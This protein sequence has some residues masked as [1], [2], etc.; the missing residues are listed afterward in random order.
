M[1]P[2]ISKRDGLS[3]DHLRK[4]REQDRLRKKRESLKKLVRG[5]LWEQ[6]PIV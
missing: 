1:K 3:P 2:L 4:I 5:N 6:L